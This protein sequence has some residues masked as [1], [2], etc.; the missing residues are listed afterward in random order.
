MKILGF[1]R[2]T[3]EKALEKETE[4]REEEE[5]HRNK[6]EEARLYNKIVSALKKIIVFPGSK[7]EFEEFIKYG[8]EWV[9]LGYTNKGLTWSAEGN[10][11]GMYSS[12]VQKKIVESGIVV[13]VNAQ[14]VLV[15][16]GYSRVDGHTLFE[17][18]YYGMPV[19]KKEVL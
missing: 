15:K 13:L 11:F 18:R 5:K 8:T 7:D 1:G 19:K 14:E 10:P 16:S 2:S 17:N 6:E 12:E 9:D 4:K 3:L